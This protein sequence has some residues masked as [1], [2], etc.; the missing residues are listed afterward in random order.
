MGWYGTDWRRQEANSSRAKRVAALEARL[1][2]T[3]VNVH[4]EDVQVALAAAYR[5][6]Q[7]TPLA[8]FRRWRKQV[9]AEELVMDSLVKL[10][11]ERDIDAGYV[12]DELKEMV[13]TSDNGKIQRWDRLARLVKLP[14]DPV[15]RSHSIQQHG[16]LDLESYDGPAALPAHE[17]PGELEG[18]V[19]QGD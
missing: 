3:G 7:K 1:I 8:T 18:D 17:V 4:A 19:E 15:K 16:R 5:P 9:E 13:V 11:E 14:V 2:L 10:L 6:K 12:L